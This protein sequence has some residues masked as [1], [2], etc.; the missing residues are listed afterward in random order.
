MEQ[1]VT[2]GTLYSSV[3]SYTE[4]NSA[5]RCVSGGSNG[6]TIT[7]SDL[8]PV[9]VLKVIFSFKS[10]R[11]VTKMIDLQKIGESPAASS[12][13]VTFRVMASCP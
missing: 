13:S 10:G 9:I 2:D 12:D 11:T 1:R 3:H 7:F 4:L 6:D 5:V 8:S